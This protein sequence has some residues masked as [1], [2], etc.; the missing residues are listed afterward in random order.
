MFGR[1]IPRD[2]QFFQSFNDLA[3]LLVA[4]AQELVSLFDDPVRAA[5][6]VRALKEIEHKADAVT[7]AVEREA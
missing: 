7:A 4:A 3:G 1:L 2:E 6:R 5:Q